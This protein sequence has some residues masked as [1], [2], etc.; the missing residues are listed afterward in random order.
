MSMRKRLQELND[1]AKETVPAKPAPPPKKANG[2]P[3]S[4]N[5]AKDDPPFAFACGHERPLSAVKV[6]CPQCRADKEMAEAKARKEAKTRHNKSKF[7]YGCQERLP[8]RSRFDVTYDAEAERWRGKLIVVPEGVNSDESWI[9]GNAVPQGNP[10]SEAWEILE[11]KGLLC[12]S[13]SSAVFE[14]LAKLDRMHR[15]WRDAKAAKT[16]A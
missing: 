6:R 5:N 2:G 12:M 9:P 1:K 13:S 10:D 15:A 16:P 7:G 4:A 11:G 3:P 8:D 14:L